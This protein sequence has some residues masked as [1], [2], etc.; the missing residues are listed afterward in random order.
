ML[1]YVMILMFTELKRKADETVETTKPVTKIPCVEQKCTDLIVL[2]LPFKSDEDDLK[3]YFSQ[4]GQLVL[5]EVQFLFCL[6]VCHLPLNHR[7][8]SS[9][10]LL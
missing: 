6:M 8:H 7:Q 1:K 9:A 4:Y 5:V 10:A 3:Q 2:G